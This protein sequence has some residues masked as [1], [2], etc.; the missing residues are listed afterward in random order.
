MGIPVGRFV[1]DTNNN[2][3]YRQKGGGDGV[4]T[5]AFDYGSYGAKFAVQATAWSNSVFYLDSSVSNQMPAGATLTVTNLADYQ[6]TIDYGWTF[7]A[8]GMFNIYT[9]SSLSGTPF[10]IHHGEQL[11][12]NWDST[13]LLWTNVP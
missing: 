8:T 2:H 4:T 11:T 12:F 1:L 9:N 13:H 3:S 6:N 10:V 7:N 5:N